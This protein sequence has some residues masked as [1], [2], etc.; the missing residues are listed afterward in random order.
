VKS[1]IKGLKAQPGWVQ[2]LGIKPKST[3]SARSQAIGVA[4]YYD[5]KRV[6]I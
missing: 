1:L 5:D 2:R 6:F 3:D 4:L